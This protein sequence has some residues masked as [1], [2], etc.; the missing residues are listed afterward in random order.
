MDHDDELPFTRIGPGVADST[1][2]SYRASGHVLLV[3]FEFW[4]DQLGSVRFDGFVGL[5]DW[6]ACGAFLTASFETNE[7]DLIEALMSRLFTAPQSDLRWRHF[8]LTGMDD[9]P[10]LEIVAQSYSLAALGRL[11]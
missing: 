6:G 9:S 10:V 2:L 4:N 8:V 3:D 5:R 1:L 7:R 11:A